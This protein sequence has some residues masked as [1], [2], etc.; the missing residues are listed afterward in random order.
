MQTT[1]EAE[2]LLRIIAEIFTYI[3][4]GEDLASPD[5][6]G[7][8]AKILVEMQNDVPADRMQAAFGALSPETQQCVNSVV[9]EYCAQSGVNLV[10][11]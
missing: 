1:T 8:L 11:P 3:S 9:N 4:D 10:S 5:T 7:R 6:Q 2:R